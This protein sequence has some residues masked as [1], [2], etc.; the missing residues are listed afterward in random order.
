MQLAHW[1]PPLFRAPRSNRIG[2][3]IAL[4]P[5]ENVC[6]G[7]GEGEFAAG[8]ATNAGM[9]MPID[10]W[11]LREACR[12]NEAWQDAS[13]PPTAA[14]DNASARQ[15]EGEEPNQSRRPRAE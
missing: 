7:L 6:P 11:V 9:R 15:F 10:D 8:A 2:D 3:S 4:T 5:N 12:R 14:S 1:S 13:L